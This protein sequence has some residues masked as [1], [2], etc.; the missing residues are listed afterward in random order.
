MAASLEED[1]DAGP[2]GVH[3]IDSRSFSTGTLKYLA[4][5]AVACFALWPEVASA[6]PT[7]EQW[8]SVKGVFDMDGPRTDGSLLV[9]GAGALFLVDAQGSQTR[10]ATGP[11]GYHEVPSGEQYVAVAHGGAVSAAG[12]SFAPDETFILRL[13]VPVGLI[14]VGANG[15]DSGSFA[16]LTGVST[17]NGIAF[18]NTGA[19]DHRLLVTGPSGSKTVV[20]A[21]DCNGGVQ[22][23]TRSAPALEGGLAVAP[24]TFGSFAGDLVAP[25]ENSGKIYAIAADGKVSTIARP[26]LPVGGDI[27]VESLGFVPPDLIAR[28]GAAYY[29]D[30]S[31]PGNPHPG[32]DNILRL[33]STDLAAAG[34]QEGDL[35]VAT[36]GGATLVDV[37]CQSSCT[38][39]PVVTTATKAHGEGHIVFTVTSPPPSPS[40]ARVANRTPAAVSPGFVDFLGTWGIAV[41]VGA[42]VLVFLVGL[43]AVALR[44]RAR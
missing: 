39:A 30:R 14:R 38:V 15:E 1:E 7:W 19:F 37:R 4:A 8:Q 40:P 31:T 44:R 21:V 12:C 28:G 2:P 9:A 34:V 29:A 3:E 6:A 26:S 18:D 16:N 10:F 32:T 41:G 23:I 11:G 17:L 25:D 33:A 42:V 5:L 24:S 13:R 27:G 35:L 22:V 20:F 43:G 36:E